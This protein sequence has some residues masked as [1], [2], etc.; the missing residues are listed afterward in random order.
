MRRQ[1]A[2]ILLFT[3][4]WRWGDG[5]GA[6]VQR[7]AASGELPS[8]VCAVASLSRRLAKGQQKVR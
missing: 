3:V 8:L 6:D 7:R 5:G 1:R 2:G 4:N